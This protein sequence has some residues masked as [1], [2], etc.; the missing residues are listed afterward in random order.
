MDQRWFGQYSARCLT[1]RLLDNDPRL[2]R[3]VINNSRSNKVSTVRLRVH[4]AASGNLPTLL[5]N[6]VK[7]GLDAVVL[8]RVLQGTVADALLRTVAKSVG[9]DVLDHGVSEL[10]VDGLVHVDALE[11]EADLTRV[12]EGEESDLSSCQY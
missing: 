12:Q 5:L 1:E 4:L 3:R 2:L 8:H 6:I 7:E 9:L 10:A 11:V